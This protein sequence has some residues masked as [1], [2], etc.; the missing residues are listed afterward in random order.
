VLIQAFATSYFY[1][2]S[3]TRNSICDVYL[4]ESNFIIYS[5]LKEINLKNF[6]I[7][8]VVVVVEEAEAAA[9]AAAA[10][11]AIKKLFIYA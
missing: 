8:S 7:I 2:K 1:L 6:S 4:K 5:Q 9:T 11:E 10:V 3:T